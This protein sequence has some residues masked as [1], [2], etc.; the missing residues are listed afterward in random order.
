MQ[1][2]SYI[3]SSELEPT[4]PQTPHNPTKHNRPVTPGP[5]KKPNPQAAP[6][7]SPTLDLLPVY[8]NGSTKA[9]KPHPPIFSPKPTRPETL[10]NP[11]KHEKKADTEADKPAPKAPKINPSTPSQTPSY[12]C[13]PETNNRAP[14]PPTTFQLERPSPPDTISRIDEPRSP[15]DLP[16]IR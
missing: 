14:Q 11:T 15:M 1:R 9:L 5:K 13:L 16:N 12:F 3:A 2:V 10:D 4:R 6:S 8:T 7:Q